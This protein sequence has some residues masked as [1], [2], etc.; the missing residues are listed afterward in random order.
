[1]RRAAW[2]LLGLAAVSC[3]GDAAEAA[4]GPRPP[5]PTTRGGVIELPEG[6]AERAG[7]TVAAAQIEEVHPV[8]HVTG[9]L[10]FDAQRLAAVGSR[11]SGRVAEVHVIEGS[12]VEADQE[13]ATLVSAE[14]GTA[15]AEIAAAE[16]LLAAAERDVARKES[17]LAEGIT[18]QRELDLAKSTRAIAAAQLR[19][20]RQRVQAMSGAKAQAE[21][22]GVV[23]LRSPIAGDVVGVHVSRGQAVVP[24]HTAF[25]IAD[26]RSLWVNLSVFEGELLHV[27]VGDP[28]EV[29]P[30]ARPEETFRGVVAFVSVGLDP[31]TRSADVRVVV[32]NESGLLRAGQAVRANIRPV[33]ARRRTV[34]VPRAAVAQIDG[35]PTLFVARDAR[36]FEPRQVTLGIGDQ[37]RVEIAAGL[38]PEERLAVSGVFALK[39]ELFR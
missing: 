5:L 34:V 14:L 20:A 12:K 7:I 26:R 33:A 11:I 29:S 18:S 3:G 31:K 19:A 1:M 15:Q 35:A 4:L 23:S 10:E 24:S 2:L 21:Q 8:V 25:M 17:L 30:S 13:L 6:Y 37:E 27:Q 32:D 39:G 36:T 38:R 28:V 9:V 16:A 22:L